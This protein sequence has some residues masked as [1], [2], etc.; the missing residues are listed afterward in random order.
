MSHR[1]AVDSLSIRYEGPALEAHRMD[2]RELAPSLLALAD[3]FT[4]AHLLTGGGYTQAPAL[5]VTA[6]VVT[7]QRERSFAVD[8]SLTTPHGAG[9]AVDLFDEGEHAAAAKATTLSASVVGAMHWAVLRHRKGREDQVVPLRPGWIRVGWPDGTHIETPG[10]AQTLVA[11]TDFN[12]M[13]GHALEPLRSEGIEEVELGRGSQGRAES[14]HVSRDDLPAFN[15]LEPEDD[16]LS[17]NVRKVAV[18]VENLAFKEG[19][20]WR[21]NDGTSSLWASVHDLPFL[22]RVSSGEA[23]FANGDSLLVEMRDKQYRTPDGGLR[24]E[25]FIERVLEHRSVPAPDMLPF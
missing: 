1:N 3:L 24:G 18:R 22:Q 25:H 5:E 23:R 16:L 13:V 10:E 2:V 21:I 4:Y 6:L 8:L 19:N 15:T 17:D 14:V 9:S 12:R 11:G 7:A 20:K